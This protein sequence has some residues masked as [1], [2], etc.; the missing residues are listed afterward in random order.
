MNK[1]ASQL[2]DMIHADGHVDFAI[3]N[4][5]TITKPATT[6]SSL[7]DNSDIKNRQ[8]KLQ[9]LLLEQQ[10]KLLMQNPKKLMLLLL[11]MIKL[12]SPR[13]K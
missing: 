11:Q 9:M 3:K 8:K 1:L 6:A 12:L 2:E 4:L 13:R 5:P 10:I 7:L